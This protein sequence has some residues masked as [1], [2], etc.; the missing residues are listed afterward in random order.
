MRLKRGRNFPYLI[1]IE[2]DAVYTYWRTWTCFS[3]PKH[4]PNWIEDWYIY[5]A[6]V[7][8]N[9]SWAVRLEDIFKAANDQSSYFSWILTQSNI[10]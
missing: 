8:K 2:I 6:I 10:K 1:K 4:A 3:F 7:I 5:S 9:Y